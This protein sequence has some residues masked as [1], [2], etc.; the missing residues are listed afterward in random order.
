VCVCVNVNRV[1]KKKE[2]TI[3]V[4]G[5]ALYNNPVN[6]LC[7]GSDYLD[8]A[9]TMLSLGVGRSSDSRLSFLSWRTK[10]GTKKGKIDTSR[11]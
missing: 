8:V 7:N 11:T 2:G 6:P 4:T 9:R 10:R 3:L 5:T 1:L